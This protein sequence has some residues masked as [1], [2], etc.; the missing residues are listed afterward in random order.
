[1]VRTLPTLTPSS[2]YARAATPVFYSADLD[3][4]VVTRDHDIEQI[5]Q[6][7]M[8]SAANTVASRNE[9]SPGAKLTFVPVATSVP[10]MKI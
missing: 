5:F 9:C 10:S 7:G 4:W 6:T 3:Y 8:F 2:L 1:M